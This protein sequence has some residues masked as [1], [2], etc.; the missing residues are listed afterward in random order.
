VQDSGI[1][2]A[3]APIV[4]GSVADSTA[5][6]T[7]SA[8]CPACQW[9]T[10]VALNLSGKKIRCKQCAGIILV[11]TPNDAVDP[12]LALSENIAQ[13]SQPEPP[14][15]SEERVVPETPSPAPSTAP[16]TK[17]P[18]LPEAAI[19][20]APAPAAAS[21]GTALFIGEISDLRSKLETARKEVSRNLE[22]L[23]Y[24]E[25]RVKS[26][27]KRAQDAETTIH[28]MAGKMAVETMNANRKISELESYIADL[29]QHISGLLQEYKTEL[30]ITEKRA[31]A[32]RTKIS[33]FEE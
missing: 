1:K 18:V 14:R 33:H 25:R 21:Q 3:A 6:S 17:P 29:E 23:N 20:P 16:E 31:A 27:E 26:A 32:L 8:K 11:P 28:N 13:E 24:A 5:S 22:Q 12:S 19:V 10:K 4:L 2:K 9:Q 30:E 7:I 15:V